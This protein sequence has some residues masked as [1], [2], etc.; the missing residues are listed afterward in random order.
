MSKLKLQSLIISVL[1]Y[2]AI[3]TAIFFAVFFKSD[4]PKAKIYTEKKGNIIEVSLGNPTSKK[5]NTKSKKKN[6]KKK[7]KKK[8]TKPK[9][10]R[11][12]KK[13]TKK[14][15]KVA[16]KTSKPTKKQPKKTATKPNTNKLFGSIGKDITSKTQDTKP[17]GKNGKSLSQKSTGVGIENKY[18][19]NIQ[20]TLKGWPAQS[21]FAGE[22]IKVELTV[23]SSGLFDY[24]LMYRSLNPE[25]NEAL[26][27]YLEQLKKIGFGAHS[28]TKPYNIVVEFIAK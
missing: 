22:T 6:T 26:K 15:T 18:F 8:K 2:I 10:I 23:Y 14:P 11:N 25:F 5:S 17:K 20:N 7:P 24:K 16:K 28:N 27:A 21:N 1:V 19:A 9:K 12:N 13:I 4:T 3:I